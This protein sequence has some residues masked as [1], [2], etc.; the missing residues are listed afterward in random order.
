MVYEFANVVQNVI[1]QERVEGSYLQRGKSVLVRG[2]KL[3][4]LLEVLKRVSYI[5]CKQ[6]FSGIIT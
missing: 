2:K 6:N 3:C 4:L 5:L 1:K